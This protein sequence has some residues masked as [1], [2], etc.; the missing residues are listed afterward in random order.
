[1]AGK[2]RG[3]ILVV[4]DHRN[5]RELLAALLESDGHEVMTAGSFQEGLRL[6]KAERFD[7]AILD[8]RL[9]DSSVYN[10]QGMALLREAKRLQPSIKAVILTGYPDP[11]Q[12]TRA[13]HFY[14]ADYYIQKAP[15][16]QPFAV[17]SFSRLISELL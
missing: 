3:H 8:M 1:M 7:A 14:G 4:D 2:K 6:L 15:E 9:V 13:L 12:E 10:I 17:D 16:G 5:W 11:D